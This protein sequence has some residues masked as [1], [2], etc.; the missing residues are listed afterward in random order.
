MIVSG[1]CGPSHS[2]LWPTLIYRAVTKPWTANDW[3][4]CKS[5]YCIALPCGLAKV[6]KPCRP[7]SGGLSLFWW[8]RTNSLGAE[9][10]W[11]SQWKFS[12]IHVCVDW[13]SPRRF[14]PLDR[15]KLGDFG[16]TFRKFLDKM[17]LQR[18]A[19]AVQGLPLHA[20]SIVTVHW[21]TSAAGLHHH[22]HHHQRGIIAAE[23][24]SANGAV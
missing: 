24:S 11:W 16:G 12:K 20:H 18:G 10:S 8:K 19:D 15:W 9:E 23:S 5:M 13:F 2:P 7:S 4:G 6:I 14:E 21:L 1:R 3:E 22:H 17:T